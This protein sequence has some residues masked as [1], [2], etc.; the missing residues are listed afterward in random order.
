[1]VTYEHFPF[2]FHTSLR[3]IQHDDPEAAQMVPHWLFMHGNRRAQLSETL[4]RV[5]ETGNYKRAVVPVNEFAWDN[6][7]EPE[8]HL[9]STLSVGAPV[10]LF[11]F[12]DV[13]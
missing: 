12:P 10:R 5:I 13:P 1:M 11:Y 9:F 4:S 8:W 6:I 2:Q 3:V 7:P